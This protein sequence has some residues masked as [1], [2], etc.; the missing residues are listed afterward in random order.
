M[1]GIWRVQILNWLICTW[2]VKLSGQGYLMTLLTLR[3]YCYRMVP[4]LGTSSAWGYQY[5]VLHLNELY[6][7][8]KPR[9]NME[10]CQIKGNNGL[11]KVLWLHLKT[12][13]HLIFVTKKFCNNP[14]LNWSHRKGKSPIVYF[15]VF[16]F[17]WLLQKHFSLRSETESEE[18][19]CIVF[20]FCLLPSFSN[21]R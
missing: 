3:S 19:I 10:R 1:A 18:N 20:N 2:H 6:N 4:N 12:K 7:E 17:H 13:S 11:I 21:T 16:F 8:R 9:K 5:G 15:K 14:L